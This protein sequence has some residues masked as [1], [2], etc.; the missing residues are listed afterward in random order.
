MTAY[1][2][3]SLL[4]AGKVY[5]VIVNDPFLKVSKL[6]RCIT[7]A[8]GFSTQDKAGSAIAGFQVF[9]DAWLN[10]ERFPFLSFVDQ[11]GDSSGVD[12][13]LKVGWGRFW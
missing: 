3:S 11:N 2:C 7:Y 12:G 6:N 9:H 13:H 5:S 4:R 10:D 1:D 8:D